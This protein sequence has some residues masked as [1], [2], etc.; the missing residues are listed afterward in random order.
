ME[1]VLSN[2]IQTETDS[3]PFLFMFLF[4]VIISSLFFGFIYKNEKSFKNRIKKESDGR[5]TKYLPAEL[6]YNIL[7]WNSTIDSEIYP[8]YSKLENIFRKICYIIITLVIIPGTML[9]FYNKMNINPD[10]IWVVNS[11]L[12]GIYIVTFMITFVIYYIDLFSKK[13]D[14]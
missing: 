2:I 7:N 6:Y 5:T 1:N 4:A 3:I 14:K 8:K 12:L 13:E 9:Y 11:I 10:L